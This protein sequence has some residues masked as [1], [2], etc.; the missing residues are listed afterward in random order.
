MLLL[1]Q[2]CVQLFVISWTEA[3]LD[4]PSFTISRSLLNFLV[5]C[6]LTL[7]NH[8]IFYCPLLIC[9]QSFPASGSFQWVSCSHQVT[10]V[11]QLQLQHQ[12]F[13]WIIQDCL[14]LGWTGWISLQS[15]RLSRVL[16]KTTVQKHQF[17]GN[18]PLLWPNSNI[19]T[20]LLEKPELWWDRPLLV[21]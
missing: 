12:S 6:A 5:H 13:P 3:Y 19:Y 21:K 18:Q 11:L 8:L 4:S 7:C 9:L 20:W 14:P 1:L 16:S 15:K 2:S 17:F 10:K